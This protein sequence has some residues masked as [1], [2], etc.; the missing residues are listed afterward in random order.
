MSDI[1]YCLNYKCEHIKCLRRNRNI[2]FN[3]LMS[4]FSEKPKLD[5]D[6]KCKKY[7]I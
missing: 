3:V 6:G 2:P 4:R 7:L 1:T 5:K